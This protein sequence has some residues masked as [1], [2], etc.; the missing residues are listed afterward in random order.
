MPSWKAL[1][2][3]FRDHLEKASKNELPTGLKGE[4][5]W[6]FECLVADGL[7]FCFGRRV[8]R[9][10]GQKRGKR[11]SDMVAP[12]P[13]FRVVVVDAKASGQGFD[14]GA[15]S[16]RAL[17]EYVNKQ[18]QR[19]QGGG[20]V[21]AALVVSS[22]FVQD[23]S[24]LAAVARTFLGDTR[25]PLCFMSAGDLW[26]TVKALRDKPDI[27]NSVRW[28]MLLAGGLLQFGQIESEFRAA[29]QERCETREM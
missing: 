16:L 2:D 1:T 23:E 3:E 13:D 17:T 26:L 4:A 15:G 5:W 18:K 6:I 20:D 7:E 11:V 12:L 9:L 19:Q 25:T 28:H 22:G 14:A 24:E 8:N 10:G 29:T 27:R 21:V